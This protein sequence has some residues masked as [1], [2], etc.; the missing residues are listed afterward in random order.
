MT[1]KQKQALLAYLGYYLGT[2]DGIWGSGSKSAAKAFRA[3]YGLK[4]GTTIDAADEKT[5]LGAVT[6]TVKPVPKAETDWKGVKYFRKEEFKCKCG[7]YCDGYPAEVDPALLELADDVREHFGAAASVSSG[8]RCNIHNANVGGAY[9]SRHMT[10][11]AM[12]FRVQDKTAAEVLAY[13]KTRKGVRYAYA[14]NDTY[15]HMDVE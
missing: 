1:V 8:L 6:G 14:I 10:G 3:A 15:V 4:A 13:V 7:R 11:K 2:I 9:K 12:D 5:L